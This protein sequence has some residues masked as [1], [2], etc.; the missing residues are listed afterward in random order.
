MNVVK[1]F[2]VTCKCGHTGSRKYYIPITFAV[3]AM[4]GKEAAA[5][6][7]QIPRCKHDHKDCIQKVE[8]CS[9][10]EFVELYKNNKLNPYLNCTCIQ[11]QK[12]LHI[13]DQFVED[14][15]YVDERENKY[16]D[17]ERDVSTY[18]YGKKRIKHPKQYMK[19]IYSNQSRFMEAY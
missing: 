10:D 1:Y 11:D 14:P 6:A 12:L 3:R 2:K 9:Y 5:I 7:R 19:N 13:E 17:E 4:N 15:H 8:E 16:E 18:Y